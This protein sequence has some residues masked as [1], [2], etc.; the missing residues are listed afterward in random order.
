MWFRSSSK[1]LNVSSLQV[2]VTVTMHHPEQQP[3]K[4]SRPP[5]ISFPCRKEGKTKSNTLSASYPFECSTS[6]T[7]PAN[8]TPMM[9][10]PVVPTTPTFDTPTSSVYG[11]EPV[12]TPSLAIS[13]S[14]SRTLLFITTSLLGSV[15]LVAYQ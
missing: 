9:P 5:L 2:P 7:P 6:T 13:I 10:S 3:G 1:C 14:Y 4:F 15:I 12:G 11:S 8:P